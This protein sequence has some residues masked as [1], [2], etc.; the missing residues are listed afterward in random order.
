[1]PNFILEI[2]HKASCKI[3]T[4]PTKL[5]PE[6]SLKVWVTICKIN[7]QYFTQQQK[8]D[9]WGADDFF[10]VSW[11]TSSILFLEENATS[12]I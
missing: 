2:E 1:M 5:H 11:N 4:L 6:P 3:G 8:E 7:T 12:Y 9:C 10:V